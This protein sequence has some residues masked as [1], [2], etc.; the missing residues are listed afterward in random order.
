MNGKKWTTLTIKQATRWRL[1]SF[2]A[3][4]HIEN[5]DL[6][7]NHLLDHYEGKNGGGVHN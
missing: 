7:V 4:E 1:K 3:R 6:A 5:L 2:V